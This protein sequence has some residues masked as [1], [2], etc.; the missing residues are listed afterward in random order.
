MIFISTDCPD[1]NDIKSLVGSL[2]SYNNTK[3]ALENSRPL[4]V[5]VRS[6]GEIVAG[7]NGYT[8][9]QWLH[10]T[11][12]WV[13]DNLRKTGLGRKIMHQIE[14][15]SIKRE[16]IGAYLDTFSFQALEFYKKIGY[17]I[18][19][20]LTDFPPGHSRYFLFKT[21]TPN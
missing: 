7:A 11:H 3:A 13:K 18:F 14:E 9:W 4:A 17:K 5:F 1:L 20:N 6:D 21:L 10:I 19:G 15:E 2:V 12:L 8:H 16:C